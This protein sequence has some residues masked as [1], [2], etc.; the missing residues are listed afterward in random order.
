MEDNI[1]PKGKAFLIVGASSGIGKA[2][3]NLFADNQNT[4]YLV[5]RNI[6]VM[7]RLKKELP[8]MIHIIP[9]DLNDLDGIK[10]NI[11][12][13]IKKNE[14]KLD[15][16]IYSAGITAFAPAKV[17]SVNSLH[18][19]MDINCFAFC[20]MARCF[21][22]P[23]ISKEGSGIV[24]ISSLSSLLS[25]KGNMAYTASKA[26]LNSAVKIMAQEFAKRRIRVNAVLPASVLTTSA[27]KK[28][29]M[30]ATAVGEDMPIPDGQ[31]FG[32]IPAEVIAKNVEFLLSDCSSFTTGELLT[33][34][35]GWAY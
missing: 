18:T 25:M 8:G 35:G 5:A 14:I 11:F 13:Y 3:V 2:C 34:G 6:E 21:Y 27:G 19:T 12:S 32:D 23:S 20:E 17:T 16:M 22:N 4:L 7:E 29:Q 28:G 1:F 33:I 10:I 9:Y 24:A 26:A 15:G 30:M 31:T